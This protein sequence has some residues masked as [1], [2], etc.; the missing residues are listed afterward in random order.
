MHDLSKSIEVTEMSTEAM[1]SFHLLSFT[2]RGCQGGDIAEKKGR[3]GG[4][5]EAKGT[6]TEYMAGTSRLILH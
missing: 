3:G 2:C 5:E 4:F 1:S 6:L